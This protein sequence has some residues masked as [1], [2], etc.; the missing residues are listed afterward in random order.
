MKKKK[1]KPNPSNIPVSKADVDRAKKQA[2]SEAVDIAWAIIFTVLRDKEGHSAEDLQRIWKGVNDL[3]DSIRQGYV[4][5]P[6]LKEV[7]KQEEGCVLEKGGG[8][9]G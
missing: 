5:V 6:D 1:K 2:V 8:T 7:L 4:T 9:N 3:S